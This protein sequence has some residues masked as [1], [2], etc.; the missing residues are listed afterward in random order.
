MNELVE[1]LIATYRLEV[2]K[3]K[4]EKRKPNFKQYKILFQELMEVM[5]K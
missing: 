4:K 1:L 3:A 2:I 5:N